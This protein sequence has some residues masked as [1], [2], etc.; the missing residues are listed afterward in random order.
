MSQQIDR[1][2][3]LANIISRYLGFADIS[4]LAKTANKSASVGVGKTLLNPS[5]IQTTCS[6]KHNRA[7]QESYLAAT[8]VGAFS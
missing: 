3:D 6:R 8:L 1:Y 2:I 7:N 5:C 4:V